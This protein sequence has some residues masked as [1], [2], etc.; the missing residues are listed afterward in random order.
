MMVL[1]V[2]AGL[3]APM[4]LLA[5]VTGRGTKRQVGRVVRVTAAKIVEEIEQWK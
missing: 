1:L 2:V 5:V 4:V 3:A